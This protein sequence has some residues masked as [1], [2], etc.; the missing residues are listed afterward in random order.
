MP[1][2]AQF[3]SQIAQ[4][5]DALYSNSPAFQERFNVWTKILDKHIPEKS[6]VLDLGCGSG[7]FSFYLA[8]QK[9]CPVTGIDG[10]ENMIRMCEARR[11]SLELEQAR[12]I[13]A[14]I[15]LSN[16]LL[17]ERFDA[18]ISSSV[19][20][21][22]DDLGA[23]LKDI[24]GR[25]EKGGVFIVSFPNKNSVYRW[26]E[27]WSYRLFGKPA[28]YQYVRHVIT[29]E[30]LGQMLSRYHFQLTHTQ[31]YATTGKVMRLLRALLPAKYATNLFVSV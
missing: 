23:V 6:K 16:D 1:T 27:K 24:D 20:E 21:Y 12:F 2:A 5:F 13:Q 14:D 19:L 7:V 3:H 26:A 18:V 8:M 30:D 28:Y 17:P 31:Y 9:H 11:K 22:I 29:P 15:P 10:A 4:N 25:L